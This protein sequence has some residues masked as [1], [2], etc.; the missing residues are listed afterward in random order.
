[1]CIIC[2]Q[3]Q[4]NKLTLQEAKNNLLEM[5]EVIGEDH[6]EEV[7]V[8]LSKDDVESVQLDFFGTLFP[9][10]EDY[11]DYDDYYDYDDD[12]YYNDE[13]IICTD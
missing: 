11:R 13:N 10:N 7:R 12:Y 6:A 2:V 4:Q 9:Q 8:M 1:M 5:T 3:Y